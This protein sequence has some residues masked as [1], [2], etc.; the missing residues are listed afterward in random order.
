MQWIVP[1][2]TLVLSGCFTIVSAAL[3]GPLEVWTLLLLF[4]FLGVTYMTF[5]LFLQEFRD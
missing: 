3:F 1:L 5:R 2:F 4:N